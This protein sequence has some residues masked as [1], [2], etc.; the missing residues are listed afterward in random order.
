MSVNALSKSDSTIL[1]IKN[2]DKCCEEC[3]TQYNGIVAASRE[4]SNLSLAVIFIGLVNVD[5]DVVEWQGEV[6]VAYGDF[7]ITTQI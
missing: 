5:W 3:T 4:E 2:S 1:C 7:N 6:I